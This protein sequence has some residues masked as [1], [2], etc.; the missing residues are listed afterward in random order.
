MIRY[1]KEIY[2][3]ASFGILVLFM[4][5]SGMYMHKDIPSFSRNT[6]DLPQLGLYKVVDV[7]K[8]GIYSTQPLCL[9]SWVDE[10]AKTIVLF[11]PNTKS[12][13]Q[14]EEWKWIYN[15]YQS[16]VIDDCKISQGDTF[17]LQNGNY[18][19]VLD[20][21]R[22]Y[23]LK[24]LRSNNISTLFLELSKGDLEDIRESKDVSAQ[25]IY[26]LLEQDG[27]TI[28]CSG[29][30]KDIHSRGNLSFTETD[31][32]SF[33]MNL[34][35]A[36]ELL[37]M[38]ESNT[39]L[40][41]AN[42]FDDS[43]SRN[44]IAG[45]LA[46][47]LEMEYIAEAEYIDL[48]IDG[49]YQGNYRLSEK[50]EI[51]K[52]RVDIRDLE[53]ETEKI[54]MEE[55]LSQRRWIEELNEKKEPVLKYVDIEYE[56]ADIQDGYLLELDMFHRYE[57][58]ASGFL[59]D[60]YQPVVMKSPEYASENQV[61]YISDR[62]QKLENALCAKNGYNEEGIHYSFYLDVNSFAKRYL[63][64]EVAKNTDASLTSFFICVPD[65]EST[66]Y[67]GPIWDYDQALGDNKVK[68][69]LSLHDPNGFYASENIY[70]DV[71]A[72]RDFSLY[73]LLCQQLDFQAEYKEIYLNG[74]RDDVF[75][76]ANRDVMEN[77]A[78]IKDSAIMNALRWNIY[79]G[80]T[81]INM[82]EK[83]YMQDNEWIKTFLI[84]RL[85]FLD[86]EWR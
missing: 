69:G 16:V 84:K 45:R 10:E 19:L 44:Y 74:F 13:E 64:D 34:E 38:D 37:G 14:T 85:E 35:E 71:I 46:E 79:E 54:N 21:K 27:K 22:Q 8:G 17:A 28:E 41:L 56:P 62:Y 67:S 70:L 53:E 76:I 51:E 52:G 36:V 48:Y 30:V 33:T 7:K 3:L 40:L 31:K 60:H 42:A 78:R 73:Y 57:D 81:D 4:F 9:N 77:A 59:S 18:E 50:V 25:G 47:E 72:D 26:Y 24:V 20:D 63:V 82:I 32:K 66:F 80:I 58:E 65:D 6:L 83:R 12:G 1:K 29:M 39:W 75:E 68:D 5:F 15:G 43:L 11:V 61:K 23:C 49:E 86:K 2:I 55:D